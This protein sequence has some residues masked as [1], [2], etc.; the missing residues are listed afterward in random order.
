M[1][2]FKKF[3]LVFEGDNVI[4]ILSYI[5]TSILMLSYILPFIFNNNARKLNTF[6]FKYAI[7]LGI[8]TFLISTV[9]IYCINS[10]NGFQLNN[11]NYFAVRLLMPIILSF[12]FVILPPIYGTII[13]NK[14]F[15]D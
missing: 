2:L 13:N 6:K 15:Y 4:F 14:R 5:I 12:N 9:L 8:L 11:F 1:L 10:L 7:A 3:N